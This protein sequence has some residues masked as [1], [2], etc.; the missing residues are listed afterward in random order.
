MLRLGLELRH[1]RYEDSPHLG[2]MSRLQYVKTEKAHRGWINISGLEAHS[3]Q[4]LGQLHRIYPTVWGH[5]RLTS[6]VYVHFTY[7]REEEKGIHIQK[8]V[9]S[10]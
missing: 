10:T 2:T 8:R 3:R 6:N 9:T 1:T 7:W 4:S 5:V